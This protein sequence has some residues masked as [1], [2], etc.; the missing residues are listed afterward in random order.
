MRKLLTLLLVISCLSAS[1]NHHNRLVKNKGVWNSTNQS[2][3]SLN[4]VPAS[5]DTIIIPANDTLVIQQESRDLSDQTLY[6]RVYGTLFFDGPA[7]KLSLASNSVIAVYNGGSIYS[8]GSASQ[9]ISLGNQNVYK[10]NLGTISGP[11][12]AT[13]AESR[14]VPMPAEAPT[15]LPVK[16]LGFSAARKNAEVLVQWAT[17]QEVNADFYEV[18][19]SVDGTNWKAIGTVKAAGTTNTTS[20]YSFIDKSVGQQTVYYRIKQ[21]DIDSRFEYTAVRTVKAEGN[22]VNAVAVRG[23]IVLQFPKQV[24]GQVEVRL[25]SMSGQV[26]S[27]Q[28]LNRPVGQLILPAA[29]KGNYILTVTDQQ[30]IQINKQILL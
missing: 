11:A 14:F 2:I 5:G 13:S 25:V 28:L 4:R 24:V 7:A 23:N 3:W 29:Y 9:I 26:V 22:P 15:P 12:M 18:Q 21:V 1:A 10:G 17:S 6:I 20:H 30:D 19:R 16:F 8:T 27:R